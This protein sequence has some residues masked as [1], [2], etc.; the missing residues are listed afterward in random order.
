MSRRSERRSRPFG[1]AAA[2]PQSVVM[3]ANRNKP[4][5][6]VF[7]IF[8]IPP[9]FRIRSWLNTSSDSGSLR[10][11]QE[12]NKHGSDNARRICVYFRGETPCHP[13]RR[14]CRTG[15][16]SF[17]RESGKQFWRRGGFSAKMLSQT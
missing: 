11:R 16:R 2:T 6:I 10:K 13:L 5:K 7:L 3:A 1:P 17:C 15:G 14:G 9:D 4:R 12:E 8:Q